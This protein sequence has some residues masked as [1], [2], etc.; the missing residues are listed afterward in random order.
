MPA[1]TGCIRLNESYHILRRISIQSVILFL[2]PFGS[3]LYLFPVPSLLF[4][5]SFPVA[6]CTFF[7]SGSSL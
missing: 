1:C 2:F 7:I 4:F 3:F 6:G 5:Q